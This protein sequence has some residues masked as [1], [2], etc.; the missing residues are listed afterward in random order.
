MNIVL[1][2]KRDYAG[3]C[4]KKQFV[5]TRIYGICGFMGWVCQASFV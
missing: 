2:R 1:L 3:C 4:L 5:G